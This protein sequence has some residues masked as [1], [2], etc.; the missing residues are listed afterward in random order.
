M[1]FIIG[2]DII[3]LSDVGPPFFSCSFPI[4]IGHFQS[5]QKAAGQVEPVGGFVGS[6]L[7]RENICLHSESL[8]NTFC[9]CEQ[10]GRVVASA[11]PTELCRFFFFVALCLQYVYVCVRFYTFDIMKHRDA[12]RKKAESHKCFSLPSLCDGSPLSGYE[13]RLPGTV[14]TSLAL[15]A[16]PI[17][18][19]MGCW[20]VSLNSGRPLN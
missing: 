5:R 16:L 6:P 7:I 17:H 14:N 13:F 19:T 4:S 11:T 15:M 18:L 9:T 12:S 10:A 20:C 1:Q 3:A 8:V 2:R